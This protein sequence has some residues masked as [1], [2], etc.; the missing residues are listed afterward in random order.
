MNRVI[1]RVD[2]WPARRFFLVF[3]CGVLLLA[4]AAYWP[5]WPGDPTRLPECAC[6]D[7]IQQSWFLY[8]AP[9]ALLHGHNPLYTSWVNWPLGANLA[10]N[11]EMPLLGV[12]T[13]PL[14]FAVSPVASFN[15][16]LYLS[17]P[18][19][20]LAMAFATRRWTASNA[21]AAAAGVLY[22]F[23]PY[24][25]GEGEGH[26][27]LTFVPLPPLI[28]LCVLEIAVHRE[29]PRRWGA[30]LGIL[31]AAQFFISPE[32]LATTL[33]MAM[34]G[35]TLIVASRWK[36][37]DAQRVRTMMTGLFVAA[38]VG[39]VL[40]A[41]PVY[42]LI[43]GP[44]RYLGP[45]QAATNG[46]RADLL[47]T[48]VPTA[49]ERFAP[50]GWKLLGDTFTANTPAENGSFLGGPLFLAAIAI[51]WRLRRSPWVRLSSVLAVIALLLSL[52]PRLV[53]DGRL[54]AVPLPFT[55]LVRLPLLDNMLPSRISLYEW[56]FVAV[57]VAL[58][59]ASYSAPQPLADTAPQSTL[60]QRAHRQP[61]PRLRRLAAWIVPALI[62][63]PLIPSWP[64]PAE[65]VSAP[66]FFTSQDVRV[67]PSGSRVLTYPFAVSPYDHAMLW[68]AVSGMRFKL[69]GGYAINPGNLN[70]GSSPW[71][72][73]LPP[74]DVQEFLGWEEYNGPVG[75]LLKTPP[76]I[77]QKLVAD[78]RAYLR[79]YQVATVVV[80]PNIAPNA[81]IVVRVFTA[82]IGRKPINRDGVQYWPTLGHIGRVE[83]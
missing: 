3:G 54:T 38:S 27:N 22:G 46:Y 47:G 5:I 32:V 37:I 74:D 59:I 20:A 66:A 31:G 13:A 33:V 40:I 58:G 28:L 6:G 25:I 15:L 10:Q 11:T 45:I 78:V 4:L 18:L 44:T 75:Y 41:Y 16:L 60:A 56:I 70:G 29:H 30:T 73:L 8:W 34:I 14:S 55:L 9:W 62:A 17:Y 39:V 79:T 52:G 36:Q 50:H 67:I 7:A 19:A 12:L 61:L 26:L 63:L 53:V 71:P 64:L 57:I 83:R 2:L 21:A 69:I 1:R 49:V 76:I 65:A 68:Q 23:S 24:V 77:D 48:L 81:A 43:A 80:D 51:A 82:A 35:L 72:P 42:F